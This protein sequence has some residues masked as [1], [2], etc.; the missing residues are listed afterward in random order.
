[1]AMLFT[2]VKLYLDANGKT[3]N[4]EDKNI[5]LENHSDGRGDIIASWNVN[6]LEQPT[7]EQLN[8][9][10]SQSNSEATLSQVSK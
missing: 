5:I 2:K 3:W 1:M 10:E 7:E 6:G 9:L 8:A 4:E